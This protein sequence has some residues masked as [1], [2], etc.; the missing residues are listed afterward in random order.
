MKR[1][2][3]LKSSLAITALGTTRPKS[4]FGAPNRFLFKQSNIDSDRIVV[5]IKLNGG[6]DGL[7]TIIPYQ[8]PMYYQLR[9][10]LGIPAD[11]TIQFTNTLALHPALEPLLPFYE[12]SKMSIIQDVGY[13]N[14]NLSHFRSSD[15]WDTGSSEDEEL[16]TGW[17]GRLLESEYPGFPENS[18]EYPLGIQ[19][20]SANLIEFKTT[21]SNTALYLYDPDTMY[22]IITGNYVNEQDEEIPDTYGGDELAF[23]REMDYMSYA[24]SQIINEAANNAPNTIL[25]YPDS[26]IGQQ[27]EITARLIAGGL[28]T[29]IYRL[30]QNGYD[31]HID[32]VG[33]SPSN[34]GRHTTLLSDLSNSL[35]VFL[36]EMDAL[37]LLDKVLV[38]TTSEFGRRVIEN[39]SLG[40]DHGTSAPILVFGASINGGIF[41]NNPQLDQLDNDGNLSLQFDYRQ[42]YSTIITDWFGLGQETSSN[43]FGQEFETIPFIQSPLSTKNPIL[44]S[45]FEVH[46]AYPNPFNPKTTIP[47]RLPSNSH[48][49]INVFNILG[50]IVQEYDLGFINSGHQMFTLYGKS[51]PSGQFLVQVITDFGVMNQKVTLLK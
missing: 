14:G 48:V 1:R 37:G 30:Y 43:V 49:K 19:F 42:I 25:N 31:T 16:T 26:I 29:P 24:Y 18:P 3:F 44:P 50:E 39:A 27:F 9:P 5:F 51:L 8:N 35:S 10:Q 13:P 33:S 41:G 32:Q 47:F 7:N 34:T 40:T 36:T 21:G 2:D 11:Q 4:L 22:A 46:P 6:N 15:I 28:E 38:I 23:L 12:N 20:N 45:K 17:I